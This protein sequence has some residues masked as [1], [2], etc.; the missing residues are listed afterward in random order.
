MRNRWFGVLEFEINPFS[1]TSKGARAE[2]RRDLVRAF[3]QYALAKCFGF[4]RECVDRTQPTSPDARRALNQAITEF[5]AFRD[6][7]ERVSSQRLLSA[8]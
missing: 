4:I 3:E 1:A 2:R 6:F 7:V 8:A 5:V